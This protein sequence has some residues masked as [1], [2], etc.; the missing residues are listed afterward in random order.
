MAT[1]MQGLMIRIAADTKQANEMLKQLSDQ[2]KGIGKSSKSAADSTEKLKEKLAGMG[3]LGG[4]IYALQNAFQAVGAS[5]SG[6]MRS[7]DEFSV[8]MAQIGIASKA[9]GNAAETQRA[10]FEMAQSAGAKVEDV[11][12]VY[13]S[14]AR[15]ASE[16]G[17]TQQRVMGI[18]Q[19][20]TDAIKAMGGATPSVTAA[21]QQFGQS[22]ASGQLRGDE[23]RSVMEQF[24]VLS[25]AIASGLGK[26]I[27]ELRQLGE[28]GKLTVTEV[29]GAIE[30]SAPTLAA[31]AAGIPLTFAAGMNKLGNAS[32]QALDALNK[33]I[34]ASSAFNAAIGAV[35]VNMDALVKGAFALLITALTVSAA[36]IAKKTVGL[37]FYVVAQAAA[38]QATL[39]AAA[40]EAAY[41]ATQAAN[42]LGSVIAVKKLADAKDALAKATTLAGGALS[43]FG[44]AGTLAGQAIQ[45]LGGPIG[46]SITAIGLLG[47]AWMAWG[48]SAKSASDKAIEASKKAREAT[49]G[50]STEMIRQKILEMQSQNASLG[51]E[52]DRQKEK[53]K[54]AF[55]T[56]GTHMTLRDINLEINANNNA[57]ERLQAL[58]KDSA[59]GAGGYLRAYLEDATRL[60][61]EQE[62][63][64]ALKEEE[65]AANQILARLAEDRKKG[66]VFRSDQDYSDAVKR[67]RAA[68]G[69]AVKEI[70]KKFTGTDDKAALKRIT[71]TQKAEF[72]AA[73]EVE[74]YRIEQET[75][76]KLA[77]REAG[78]QLAST[79]FAGDSETMDMIR[80]QAEQIS[81]F[82][83]QIA[84]GEDVTAA[85]DASQ[86]RLNSIRSRLDAEVSIGLKS[87]T[88]AQ[89][90]LR[91]ETGKLGDELSG[92]LLPR[93]RQL[94]DA[95]PDD[96]TREKWRA[97]YAEIGGMQATGKQVGPFAGLQAGL[98]DYAQTVT[99]TFS[100]V[101][102]S[103]SGAFKGM[104]D[105][106]TQ[107]VMTGKLDF[108]SLANSII[109]DM[110]R[111]AVQASITKPLAGLF[112]NL[113]GSW[114]GG[115]GSAASVSSDAVTL[116][117]MNP[118]AKGGTPPGIS[119][120]RNQ[121]VDKPTFFAKGG[122]M[123]EAGPEAIM[124]ISKGPTGRLGVD[125]SGL[126][127]SVVVNVIN[128]ASGTQATSRERSDGSGGKII[129]VLIEQVK[130]AIAGDIARGNGPVS[131]A[132][133]STYG[134]NRVAGAY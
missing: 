130:G 42:G 99:D 75:K 31:A 67:V 16:L 132:L 39:R 37:G 24:P 35:S 107:F 46:A 77:Q 127:T 23:L 89:I 71:D 115:A 12:S 134:L 25:N 90:E 62:K 7:A 122:I 33:S 17:L 8:S 38:A 26:S 118:Y 53:T 112:S 126:G 5:L 34:G 41:A 76:L 58:L 2:F 57:I 108:K 79:G 110:V 55:A 125:A 82:Y 87:Q 51:V 43:R 102:T 113:V 72:D 21:L 49:V 68:H 94:I 85:F 116:A 81:Q 70:T 73:M 128:N 80:Q 105:A 133:A 45:L 61:K 119:A 63:Q 32:G 84:S 19:S 104:E 92:S 6:A 44:T 74:D 97:L 13:V 4:A 66:G 59:S 129:D 121:I 98:N 88:A 91:Q 131:G 40:S 64:R 96:A 124:P 109:A 78:R 1:N 48:N 9:L 100:T 28:A 47:A 117:A 36:L 106:L 50:D 83:S 123:G 69:E 93:L 60:T 15:N 103:V 3:H 101:K 10:I 56:A 30:K 27:G 20:L 18:T 29:L 65:K 54:S 120:W 14:I 11:G 86:A 95:A 22:I 114:F 52:A 111:M